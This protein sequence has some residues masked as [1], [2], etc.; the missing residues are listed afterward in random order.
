LEVKRYFSKDSSWGPWTENKQG[1]VIFS[2]NAPNFEFQPDNGV[3]A[4]K[5]ITIYT[6]AENNWVIAPK[7]RT[8][9]SQ[10]MLVEVYLEEDDS[11]PM[12]ARINFSVK[13]LIGIN[14]T[15]IAVVSTISGAISW[16]LLSLK[17]AKD[18]VNKNNNKQK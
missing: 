18:I 4:P 15:T 16:I 2:L 13:P 9:G 6:P 7:E 1:E 5:K 11:L 14:A 3:A 17:T 12:A 8:L 10:T